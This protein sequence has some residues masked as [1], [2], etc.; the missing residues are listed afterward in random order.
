MGKS[1]FLRLTDYV[2]GPELCELSPDTL[3]VLV[4]G[5]DGSRLDRIQERSGVDT[6]RFIAAPF[7]GFYIKSN[8]SLGLQLATDG[9][10]EIMKDI[11]RAAAVTDPSRSS[12]SSH[13]S[14]RADNKPKPP[15]SEGTNFKT[16]F[17][18]PLYSANQYHLMPGLLPTPV[19]NC[20]ST[21]AQPPSDEEC[22]KILN[23]PY[24][25]AIK[26]RISSPP[27][28]H[29]QSEEEPTVVT[30]TVAASA[31]DKELEGCLPGLPGV[32]QSKEY[33]RIRRKISE[34]DDLI[35]SGICLD[36]C[37]RA[38]VAKRQDYVS[39]LRHMLVHGVSFEGTRDVSSE[40]HSTAAT[41]TVAQEMVDEVIDETFTDQLP[42]SAVEQVVLP[43]A[44][45]P[46]ST[47]KKN[48]VKKQ[49]VSSSK[50]VTK[51]QTDQ[52]PEWKGESNFVYG[53]LS[54]LLIWVLAIFS[55]Y[56]RQ[57]FGRTKSVWT[58]LGHA[59]SEFFI[60]EDNEASPLTSL[61]ALKT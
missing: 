47:S 13:T 14:R 25:T 16:A 32:R 46:V 5:D 10:I 8:A 43:L 19:V 36:S 53:N 52:A 42:P 31:F 60:G 29:R 7:P 35:K 9:V 28:I 41:T 61:R 55:T 24:F 27:H 2:S 40:I 23:S 56:M 44:P 57:F 38:K 30:P 54:D 34:I 58:A 59:Y 6:L 20:Q 21:P 1:I 17:Y 15:R 51:A 49:K 39:Q 4:C 11:K 37:Q 18:H 26:K 48:K 3:Q 22:D 33:K 45:S 50:P 12:S